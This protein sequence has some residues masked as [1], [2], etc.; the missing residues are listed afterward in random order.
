MDLSTDPGLV[1]GFFLSV[2][3]Y[4]T[5]LFFLYWWMCRRYD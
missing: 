3:G 5:F 4:V 2:G 1:I